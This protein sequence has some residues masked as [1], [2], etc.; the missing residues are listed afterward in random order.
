MT[1][2]DKPYMCV[3]LKELP[4]SERPRE[5]LIQKGSDAL[6]NLD[7]MCL[8]LGSGNSKTRVQDVAQDVLDYIISVNPQN[9]TL[10]D[11]TS[12][13]GMGFAKSISVISAMELGKRLSFSN[14]RYFRSP[15]DVWESIKHY[16]DSIQEHFICVM[17]NG[18]YEIIDQ[19]VITT[20]LVNKTLIHP[21]EVFAPAI[22]KRATAIIIAHNH[23]SGNLFPSQ[24]D[25]EVTNRLKKAGDLLGIPL[26]DHIIFSCD[27]FC[28]L[29]ETGEFYF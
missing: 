20:G 16:D 13:E 1:Y 6:S 4:V 7:L 27:A 19:S 21:R 17:L 22:E 26:I 25:L 5:K 14:H 24:D 3:S 8:L 28:S 11:L 29:A 12:I 9:I 15:Q 10:S 23:P 18:G 2:K